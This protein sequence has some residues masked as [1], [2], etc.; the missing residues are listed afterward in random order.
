YKKGASILHILRYEINNDNTVHFTHST[1]SIAT[2]TLPQEKHVAIY[3]RI[4]IFSGPGAVS[5]SEEN[6]RFPRDGYN[7]P[8]KFQWKE[9]SIT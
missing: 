8:W 1:G 2:I 5:K 7:R 3:G 9:F 4:I 6:E